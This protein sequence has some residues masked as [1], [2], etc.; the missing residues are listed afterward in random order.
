MVTKN[1]SWN[2][3]SQQILKHTLKLNK[4]VDNLKMF[5]KIKQKFKKSGTEI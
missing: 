1:D 4:M 5:H 3:K 2:L